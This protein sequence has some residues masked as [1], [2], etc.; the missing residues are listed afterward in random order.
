MRPA[1]LLQ[2]WHMTDAL[3]QQHLD[4]IEIQSPDFDSDVDC[5]SDVPTDKKF[6]AD[7]MQ[8]FSPDIKSSDYQ[9]SPLLSYRP[10]PELMPPFLFEH[11]MVDL[12]IRRLYKVNY[13]FGQPGIEW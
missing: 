3:N 8:A 7:L 12:K 1:S 6:P 13:T 11:S 10:T 5:G 2:F 4:T 9:L